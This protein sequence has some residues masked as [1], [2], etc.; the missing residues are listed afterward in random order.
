MTAS[1]PANDHHAVWVPAQ[2]RD[3]NSVFG[4]TAPRHR[5]RPGERRD[6]YRGC[7]RGTWLSASARR[8]ARSRC[9]PPRLRSWL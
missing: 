4:T 3:D 5:C 1:R 2:G 9:R 8:R 7:Y 6:P